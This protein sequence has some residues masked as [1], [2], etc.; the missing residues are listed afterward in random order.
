[1]TTSD[2]RR[3]KRR[4][5]IPETSTKKRPAVKIP[6][7][8]AITKK[9]PQRKIPESDDDDVQIIEVRYNAKRRRSPVSP[10]TP[11]DQRRKQETYDQS[12]AQRYTPS[13]RASVQQR[14]NF[15]QI[16]AEEPTQ[17]DSDIECLDD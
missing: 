13:P 3:A 12:P 10:T 17:V 6:Q 2:E 9:R 14:S 11:M 7:K 4:H 8:P 15:V 1:M 16:K 5:T